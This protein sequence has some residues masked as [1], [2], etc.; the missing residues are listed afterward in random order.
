MKV[1]VLFKYFKLYVY[2]QS[3]LLLNLSILYS[4]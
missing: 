1:D 4:L 2:T 3:S